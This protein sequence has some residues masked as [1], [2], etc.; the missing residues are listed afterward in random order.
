MVRL[1][2]PNHFAKHITCI[3]QYTANEIKQITQE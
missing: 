3:S 1:I 2:L